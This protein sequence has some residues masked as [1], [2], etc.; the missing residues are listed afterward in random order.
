MV[1]DGHGLERDA[2][3]VLEEGVRPPD[4]GEPLDGQEAILGGHVVREP[5]AVVLLALSEE[6]VAR[7]R[8]EINLSN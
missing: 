4:L 7:V 1:G 8:L 5:E 2:L 3:G 6:H